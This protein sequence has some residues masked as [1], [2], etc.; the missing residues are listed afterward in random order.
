MG[1]VAKQFGEPGLCPRSTPRHPDGVHTELVADLDPGSQRRPPYPVQQHHAV[2]LIE[3]IEET[4]GCRGR[5]DAL[6]DRGQLM[7]GNSRL[8]RPHQGHDRRIA[9][10]T[11][12]QQ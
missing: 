7:S 5:P 10:E 8:G 3:L 12:R 6:D 1:G 11:T 2:A 4:P 9:G